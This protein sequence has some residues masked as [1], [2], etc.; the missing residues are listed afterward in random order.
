MP[1]INNQIN[2]ELLKLLHGLIRNWE[3]EVVE[4]KQASNSFSQDEIGQYFSALSNEAN[5]KGLKH[6]W[7]IFGVHNVTREIVNTNYRDTHGLEVLKHEIADN[8][9]GR[10]TFADVYEVFDGDKRVIMFKI[11]A[12]VTGIPTAWKGHW[13]GREGESLSPLSQDE[14]DRIRGQALPDWSSR[15][16]EDSDIKYLDSEAMQI[17]RENYKRKKN[18]EHIRTEVDKMTDEEFLTKLMLIKDGKLTNAAMVLLGNPDYDN[19]FDG[20]ARV[21]WRL[22]GSNGIVKDYMEFRIP[23]ITVVDR[24]YDKIR[25]LTYRYLPNRKTL[26]TTETEQ[27]DTDLV[28]ELLNNC[29]AHMDYTSGGRIYLDEFEDTIVISN[30]GGFIPGDVRKVLNPGYRAPYYRNQLI[31]ESMS[32]FDMIDTVQMGILKVYNIQRERY[33]PLPDYDV[34]NANEV[35]VRV[36]GKILSTEYTRL[37]FDRADLPI[38]TVYLLD[39]VQK[40]LPLEKEQYKMLKELNLIEGKSPNYYISLGVSEVIDERVQ[41]TRNKAMDDKY[42]KDLIINYLQQFGTGTKAD[43]IKLLSDKLSDVL[44]DKQKETKVRSLIRALQKNELIEHTS[45]N[46]RTGV[47]RLVQKL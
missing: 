21:M 24:A 19:R 43:F 1:D 35:S 2:N 33:F 16:I 45:E 8:A 47:W 38:D 3:H 14:I 31:A 4:F 22:Y 41:Y 23:F 13:Y 17:A 39:R 36:Y 26:F 11:P 40:K 10:L 28:K 6:G 30:P 37:L 25:K 44:D 9:T 32:S 15:V 46:K 42:Y 12:A 29:V 34:E 7:L 20:H 27:Y 5:L 18:R